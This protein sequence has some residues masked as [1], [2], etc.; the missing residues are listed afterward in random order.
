MTDIAFSGAIQRI[1]FQ[2]AENGFAIFSIRDGARGNLILKGTAPNIS[3]GITVQG[4]GRLMQDPKWGE[5]VQI[6][7]LDVSQ[8]TDL[9]GIEKYLSS[10]FI[11]GVGE[12][13]ARDIVATFGED[14]LKVIQHEPHRLT[15]VPGVGRKRAESICR[16]ARSFSE[17]EDI[18]A[19]L[20][21]HGL[22]KNM[23]IRIHGDYGKNAI[24][25]ISHNPWLLANDINGI[26]FQSADRVA[27]SLNLGGA[28]PGRVRAG[29]LHTLHQAHQD[30]HTGLPV[31][32]LYEG[33]GKLLGLDPESREIVQ[34]LA[35]LGAEKRIVDYT[36]ADSSGRPV[37]FIQTAELCAAERSLAT[38]LSV[39]LRAG[40]LP[41]DRPTLSKAIQIEARELPYELSGDQKS[42]LNTLVSTAAS[43][44]VGGPGTGKS[45]ITGLF[46]R[47]LRRSHPQ[48]SVALCA[49]TGKAAQRL[50]EATGYLYPGLTTHKLLGA[51][52]GGFTYNEENPLEVQ[53]IVA[54]ESSMYDV[55]LAAALL[56]AVSPGTVIL[57]VG[58]TDQLP[59]VG[60][61]SVLG[62]LIRSQ[63]MPVS[64]LTEIHRQAQKSR[65]ITNAHAI[66]RGEV[67]RIMP[68]HD[69]DI[70]RFEHPEE[71]QH[72]LARVLD[73]R[74]PQLGYSISDTMI[75]TAGHRS[76]TGTMAMNEYIKRMVNPRPEVSIKVGKTVFGERDRIIVN[77]N[78]YDLD[79]RNGMMGMIRRIDEEA[80][81]IH[82][83]IEGQ[84][85]EVTRS[86]MADL[87]HSY[88]ITIHRSQGSQAPCVILL[89]D[90][91]HFTLLE[92]SLI[93]TGV[94]RAAK[95]CIL[96]TKPEALNIA[97]RNKKARM[98]QTTLKER[99]QE[100]MPYA[101]P[102][103]Q[104]AS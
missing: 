17:I 34:G 57:F 74:L 99:L 37:E 38:S 7:Q 6:T 86:Q 27:A 79:V 50:A 5:Q 13:L 23:A 25:K 16:S 64:C 20:M 8:P 1:R 91:S 77:R 33:T 32:A 83:D 22:S 55:R 97:V 47:A 29:L 3:E 102:S 88:C 87:T 44:M 104:K 67:K 82:V 10:G 54:D 51:G 65:I 43:L 30:G 62:D 42:A 73:H 70:E 81:V 66:N 26:G 24:E 41:W 100:L 90:T 9:R 85:H 98:R 52:P 93:Y 14:A 68:G 28:H 59:S 19:F 96:I 21:K 80:N 53:L 75:L 18:M 35:R 103:H 60:P 94:T 15:E 63:R 46:L 56:R 61:G 72:I 92:R 49:P 76:L 39:L 84:L 58:D 78:N 36:I 4:H 31:S 95:H 48:I 45:S 12:V 71:A 89:L 11:E 101:H 40:Q 2:N 69:F